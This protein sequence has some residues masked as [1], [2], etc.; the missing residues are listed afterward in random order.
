M[1]LLAKVALAWSVN[2]NPMISRLKQIFLAGI[3]A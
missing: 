2:Y 1:A 3:F